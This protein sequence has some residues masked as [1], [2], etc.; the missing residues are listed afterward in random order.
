MKNNFR[1]RWPL[2]LMIAIT[3]LSISYYLFTRVIYPINRDYFVLGYGFICLLLLIILTLYILR[4]NIYSYRIGSRQAWLQSHVYIGIISLV[5][6]L[7]HADFSSSGTFSMILLMLY[8]LTVASGVVG[9]LIYRTIPLSLIKF[10]RKIKAEDE[11][12][13]DLENFL[14]EA[15]SLVSKTSSEFRSIYEERVR[16]YIE[17]K[18]IKWEYLFIEERELL[19]KRREMIEEIKESVLSQDMHDLNTLSS[20]FI[21]AEKNS[22]ILTKLKIQEAWLGLHTPL[23]IALLTGT[24]IHIAVILYY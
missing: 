14:A 17:S 22:F 5:L 4:E 11:L 19:D 16:P 15:D 18:R 6:L 2:V 1:S 3:L 8:L 12:V 20:I 23:T 24:T 9:A 10:G 21:E 13:N 7:M